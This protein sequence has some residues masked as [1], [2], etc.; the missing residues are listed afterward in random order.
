M[1]G[2][3]CFMAVQVGNAS[4]VNLDS[5]YNLTLIE[6]NETTPYTNATQ[7][8]ELINGFVAGYPG[9]INVSFDILLE[10]KGGVVE[11]KDHFVL[12]FFISELA[13]H[14][15]VSHATSRHVI[16]TSLTRVLLLH[17]SSSR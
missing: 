6:V 12:T 7:P 15:K 5:I 10:A 2:V 14:S 11:L 13:L 4:V 8:H 3:R 1:V 9:F 17:P 16:A